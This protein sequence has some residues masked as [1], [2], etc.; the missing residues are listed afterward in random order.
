MFLHGA[1]ERGNDLE[2]VKIHG[3]PKFVEGG[4]IF[5]FVTIAPQCPE[6]AEGWSGS[7]GAKPVLARDREARY[8][9]HI[10]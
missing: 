7:P 3:K 4:R 6:E 10:G 1:G 2:L 5:P 9:G 8:T